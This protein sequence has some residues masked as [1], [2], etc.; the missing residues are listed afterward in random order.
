[1][2]NKVYLIE[3]RTE[4]YKTALTVLV[5]CLAAREKLCKLLKAIELKKKPGYIYIAIEGEDI[6]LK[7]IIKRY[8]Y[9]IKRLEIPSKLYEQNT[10]AL[11]S[12]TELILLNIYSNAAGSIYI[13]YSKDNEFK[14]RLT[15]A[16][17]NFLLKGDLLPKHNFCPNCEG[18]GTL[19]ELSNT[20][21]HY[22]CEY[23][24]T[25]IVT[26]GPLSKK[27]DLLNQKELLETNPVISQFNIL[28]N[29]L[30]VAK[31]EL[32][33][34]DVKKDAKAFEK[35]KAVKNKKKKGLS[36]LKSKHKELIY[37]Y[38]QIVKK[39]KELTQKLNY[40]TEAEQDYI[41]SKHNEERSLKPKTAV[42]GEQI[43]WNEA[44]KKLISCNGNKKL[45]RRRM[46]ARLIKKQAVSE[47]IEQLRLCI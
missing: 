23:C 47:E 4:D 19:I 20:E 2:N 17:N 11:S 44:C 28:N 22:K 27:H 7:R 16:T 21:G 42:F 45:R 25:D 33:S 5:T 10:A 8:F 31:K 43:I 9:K 46:S 26:P 24:G 35:L 14:K 40:L 32:A 37:K 38:I 1:M 18:Y 3:T 39:Y 30:A 41:F 15:R 34:V 13:D 6:F 12:L 36:E 29:E